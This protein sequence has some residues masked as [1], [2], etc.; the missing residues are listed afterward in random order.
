IAALT[1]TVEEVT[2]ARSEAEARGTDTLKQVAAL[3]TTVDEVTRARSDAEQRLSK[4]RQTKAKEIVRSISPFVI[5]AAVATLGFWIYHLVWS[6]SEPL[7]ASAP[8]SVQ[9]AA[10]LPVAVTDEARRKLEEAE[11]FRKEAERQANLAADAD[12]KGQA[13]E[14]EQ[15][16]LKDE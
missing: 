14:A 8:P 6:A 13:A 7:T 15:Q 4:L 3:R 1:G 11:Q 5:A 16:R 9:E 2:R 12:T 10:L